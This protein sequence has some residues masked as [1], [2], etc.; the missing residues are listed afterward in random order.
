MPRDD[1]SSGV[2]RGARSA[3][4]LCFA[5]REAS[6]VLN[7]TL[8]RA[9]TCSDVSAARREKIT[10]CQWGGQ[11]LQAG[12]ADERRLPT[13]MHD[14]ASAGL[15]HARACQLRAGSRA[16]RNP[17][18]ACCHEDVRIVHLSGHVRSCIC[19]KGAYGLVPWPAAA[20]AKDIERNAKWPRTCQH[21]IGQ[22]ESGETAGVTAHRPRA[23]AHAARTSAVGP[24]CGTAPRGRSLERDRDSRVRISRTP[25][26]K[27]KYLSRRDHSA[28]P[29]ASAKDG[30][31]TYL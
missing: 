19:E 27:E 12:A 14:A 20:E 7:V 9:S 8:R 2:R 16:A 24:V 31:A 6:R 10:V 17:T 30:N 22:F 11:F 4:A 1:H 26:R 29:D 5:P 28:T 21:A 18:S 23:S 3:C 13:A 15:W 25:L